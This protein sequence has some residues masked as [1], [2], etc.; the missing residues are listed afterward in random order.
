MLTIENKDR[1]ILK[2]NFTTIPR[3]E[4][5]ED[6]D[7][8]EDTQ[9]PSLFFNPEE[10]FVEGMTE[11]DFVKKYQE[12]MLVYLLNLEKDEETDS[13][14]LSSIPEEEL[15]DIAEIA[16]KY[17]ESIDTDANGVLSKEEIDELAGRDGDLELISDDDI[18][19]LTTE[20]FPEEDEI[21]ELQELQE[22]PEPVP[23]YKSDGTKTDYSTY[24][25]TS[26]NS[27]SQKTTAP[28]PVDLKKQRNEAQAK[29]DEERNNLK[30]IYNEGNKYIQTARNNYDTALQND[31]KVSDELKNRQKENYAKM[32]AL[33]QEI[34]SLKSELV[35]VNADISNYTSIIDS[36]KSDISALD[37]ALSKLDTSSA[38]DENSKSEI[39]KKRS[40]I[41][42]QKEESE[43]IIEEAQKKLDSA[44]KRK[45]EIE[46][47]LAVKE[48]EYKELKE[49]QKKIEEQISKSC[50]DTT[51][52]LLEEYQNAQKEVKD[53]ED[54]SNKKITELEQKVNE[55]DKQINSS[56]AGKIATKYAP[57]KLTHLVKLDDGR[58]FL[59]LDELDNLHDFGLRE[60]NA[61]NFNKGSNCLDMSLLYCDDFMDDQGTSGQLVDFIDEDPEKVAL[62]AK[63]ALDNGRPVILHVGTKRDTRHFAMAVGYRYAEDG[64]I[65]FLLIDN[66]LTGDTSD[67]VN[68][69]TCGNA[70]NNKRHFISGHDTIYDDQNYGYRCMI[71]V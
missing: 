29:L 22:P 62:K 3:D 13:Y 69:S 54:A 8:S 1:Y 32:T 25:P 64:S 9:E 43:K 50:D 30:T 47:E 21:E 27:S 11:D 42:A 41:V 5:S 49:A 60:I 38:P 34:A 57:T 17:F 6:L 66:C 7:E 45:E 40:D 52:G 58:E 18:I 23:V 19:S 2:D 63:E 16:K 67:G 35:D 65:E 70:A 28:T 24:S 44:N 51:K 15:E 12:M 4:I 39:E 20:L 71:Y 55:L 26:K 14:D 37:T 68:I 10:L 31:N 46:E 48:P 53:A 33:E 61:G 59:A 56:E 36:K